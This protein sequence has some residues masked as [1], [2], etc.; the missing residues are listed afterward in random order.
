MNLNDTSIL[1][2]YVPEITVSYQEVE[3]SAQN[4][5]HP[6][7]TITLPAHKQTITQ[8]GIKVAFN[9]ISV[10][11]GMQWQV[12][13]E[14]S[15]P[16]I[17]KELSI[18]FIHGFQ[19]GEYIYL[20]GYQSWTDSMEFPLNHCMK[21]PSHVLKPLLKKYQLDRYGDYTFIPYLRKKGELHGF[22]YAYIKQSDTWAVL[23]ASLNEANGFTI[24]K[25]NTKTGEIILTK[26]LEGVEYTFTNP[27]Y[28]NKPIM[29]ILVQEG[30]IDDVFDSY[31]SVLNKPRLSAEPCT[32]WTSWY[33]YYQNISET[34]I[35][36]NLNAFKKHNIP[37]NIFQ[38]DDG[39]QTAVGD[40]LSL[41][42]EFSHG[43]E[44]LASAIREA[45]YTPGLWLAPLVC[46]TK[47]KIFQEHQD[48][49]MRNNQGSIISC[50]GNWSGFY[51][52]D[53]YKQEVRAYLKEVF[54]T[55]LNKWGFELVK[56]DFLYAACIEPVYGKSRGELMEDVMLLLRELVGSKKILGCG[57]P[58]WHAF[59]KVEFCRI[60]P[61]IDLQ[62][63]NK[64][65]K[66][67]AHR[68]RPSTLTA[69]QNTIG[70]YHLDRRAFINDP[71]VF[72]LRSTNL[73]LSKHEKFTLILANTALGNVLFTS[74]N[75]SEYTEDQW[76][77]YLSI[78]PHSTKIINTVKK[79]GKLT[80]VNLTIKSRQYS[81]LFNMT[82]HKH[83]VFIDKPCFMRTPDAWF[84]IDETMLTIPAH[85]SV[86]LFYPNHE[87][88]SIIGSTCSL[89]AGSEIKD[90]AYTISDKQAAITLELNSNTLGNGK[91][92]IR[93]PQEIESVQYNDQTLMP[94]KQ[95]WYTGK[96]KLV[97]IHIPSKI[98]SL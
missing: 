1:S 68:E 21:D 28:A 44:A 34:I 83:A 74:D 7:A 25:T 90:F 19:S 41:K 62:W 45:G 58:L 56:L 8:N 10:K 52:L 17:I 95:P 70:R 84:W 16:I 61:D 4:N 11:N 13:V 6:V 77:L 32:G 88:I 92:F 98:T 29:D 96:G 38:I 66:K 54:D 22:S 64:L 50:G 97:T 33:N 80:E 14:N 12:Y 89:Y 23:F 43:M 39:Y 2:M 18:K 26:D 30:S 27:P 93:V 36:D 3:A 20:N 69:I 85:S 49:L 9:Q 42:P 24:I 60:G 81:A 73:K 5:T 35:L 78:F 67:I 82:E 76:K 75:L 91:L 46:E 53:F 87:P 86:C 65:Y 94:E 51:T 71:D 37:I 72:L 31:F 40:W 79:R 48:W 59:G 47:S 55:V 63:D 57:V 15:A